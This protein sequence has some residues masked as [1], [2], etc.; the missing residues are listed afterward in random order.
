M[1]A[2]IDY[3]PEIVIYCEAAPIRSPRD[4]RYELDALVNSRRNWQMRRSKA[5][6]A[7]PIAEV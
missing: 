5:L 2:D 6:R 4:A 1:N 7:E 3:R